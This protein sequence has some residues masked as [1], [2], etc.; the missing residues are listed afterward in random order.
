MIDFSALRLSVGLS[1]LSMPMISNFTP[2]G[3]LALNFSAKNWKLFN[4][5]APTWAIRPDSGSIHAILTVSPASGLADLS[6]TF[7]AGLVWAAASPGDNGRPVASAMLRAMWASFMACLLQLE[8]TTV[9][10]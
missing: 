10:G 6:A 3:L 4:W 2:A 7:A 1:L 5:F 8:I 9:N